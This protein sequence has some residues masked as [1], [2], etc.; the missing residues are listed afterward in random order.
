M[1]SCIDSRFKLLNIFN[2]EI[3]SITEL[4]ESILKWNEMLFNLMQLSAI[5]FHDLSKDL[6]FNPVPE[7]TSNSIKSL[8]FEIWFNKSMNWLSLNWCAVTSRYSSL[9]L[10]SNKVC[11]ELNSCGDKWKTTLFRFLSGIKWDKGC[12]WIVPIRSFSTKANDLRTSL[13]FCWFLVK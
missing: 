5:C 10:F 12:E 9:R 6:K 3:K 1:G 11:N 8:S 4:F 13:I 2:E 7:L